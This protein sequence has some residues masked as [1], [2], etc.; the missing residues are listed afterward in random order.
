MIFPFS[1]LQPSPPAEPIADPDEV[2]Q[3]YRY[4]Q[5]R[6]LISSMIGYALFYFVRKNLSAA[7]PVMEETLGIGKSQL[8]LFLTLHGLLYGI[9]KF[10]N[11]VIGDRANARWFMVLGLVSS[12]VVNILFGFSSAIITFGLFWMLN[13]WFQGMGFPP[14]ARLMT[15]WFPPKILATKMSIWNTSHSIG[16]ALVVVLCGYLAEVDWRLCFFVPAGIALAGAALLAIALRDTPESLGL[17]EVEGTASAKPENDDS[18]SPG[19]AATLRDLVFSNPYIW[20]ISVANFFVYTVRYGILDWGFAFLKQA[21]HMDLRSAGLIV[22]AFEISG[23]TGMLV[24]GWVTDKLF[25][26]RGTRTCLVYMTLCFAALLTFWKLDSDSVLVN[27][28]LL[29]IAG[30]FIYGPQCLVGIAVA[31][32]ATKR[33]AAAAVGLTGVFGYA[34]TLLSGYGMG[35]LVEKYDWNAGFMMLVV[36]TMIGMVLF[37]VCWNARADG[38]QRDS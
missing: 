38:Y 30:F 17:P 11:G 36:A 15:H 6:I 35:R 32:L 29:C 22:A 34:S 18:P 13:G 28:V 9:S 8:G 5:N 10:A 33:A 1:L 14:C 20:L 23:I 19:L 16:A 2:R 21:K 31:N 37:A 12:A 7:M 3:R 26:G 27:T 4:W 24:S 25:G